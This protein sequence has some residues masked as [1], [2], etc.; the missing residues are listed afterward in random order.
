MAERVNGLGGAVVTLAIVV[1][2]AGSVLLSTLGPAA[3]IGAVALATLLFL[4]VAFGSVR[5]G[6]VVVMA[7]VATAPMYKGL[8]PSED[9][10]VT[11]TDVLFVLGF[12][13]LLPA[14]LRG[15]ISLPLSYV[16]GMSLVLVAGIIATVL[17]DQR[18]LSGLALAL[19]LIVLVGLPVAFGL[20]GPSPKLVDLL[21]WSYV[22]GH[23]LS[24]V[25][26]AVLGRITDDGRHYGYTNHPNYFGQAGMMAFA[27]LLYLFS[28]S[29]SRRQ[30]LVVLAAGAVCGWSVVLSGSRGALVVLIMLVCMIPVVERSFAAG[31]LWSLAGALVLLGIPLIL[32]VAGDTPAIERLTGNESAAGSDQIRSQGL[33]AGLDRLW[34]NPF[35]GDGLIDLFHIHNN[36][37]EVAV[38]IGVFGLIGYVAVMYAFARPLLGDHELRRLCYPVWAYLAWGAFVPGLYDRSIWAAVAI[39]SVVVFANRPAGVDAPARPVAGGIVRTDAVRTP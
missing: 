30:Q 10:A 17:S 8:A 33:E 25:L 26:G 3:M 7:A 35:F 6:A 19:W 23:L 28:R 24:Q 20:W 14:L 11:P 36:Y 15:R 9:A 37:L 22:A 1:V 13:L 18:L 38:G 16:G 5:V 34:A 2:A 4:V 12:A 32:M 27:L 39:S 31:L 29:T 21:V